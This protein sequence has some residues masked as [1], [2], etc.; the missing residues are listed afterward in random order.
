MGALRV[1]RGQPLPG[2]REGQAVQGRGRGPGFRWLAGKAPRRDQ[3]AC[4]WQ[5][6][7]DGCPEA[8]AAG[9][10]GCRLAPRFQ[11]L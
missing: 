7:R 5:A 6:V 2:A 4:Q 11:I 3:A 10:G 1:L 8:Q 9:Q